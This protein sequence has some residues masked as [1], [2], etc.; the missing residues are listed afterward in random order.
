MKALSG[1]VF[2]FA[3]SV[4]SAALAAPGAASGP[5]TAVAKGNSATNNAVDSTDIY[6][7]PHRID[8]GY[9][10]P[11]PF[12]VRELLKLRELGLKLQKEDGGTLTAEDR[13]YLQATLDAI[14]AP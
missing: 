12:K 1:I 4:A 7:R 14:Q 10:G 2:T 3:L 9:H 5:I 6:Y 13:A 11:V 8:A